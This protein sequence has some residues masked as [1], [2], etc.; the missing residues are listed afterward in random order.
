[1]L[2]FL[3]FVL[4]AHESRSDKLC[5]HPPGEFDRVIQKLGSPKHTEGLHRVL[6]GD[7]ATLVVA[8]SPAVRTS[9]AHFP[10]LCHTL[11]DCL[12]D[13]RRP[14][15]QPSYLGTTRKVALRPQPIQ[16]LDVLGECIADEGLPS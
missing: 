8:L 14:D 1:M 16:G 12:S 3:D 4:R 2:G 6:Y 10:V 15:M 11:W 5:E 7:S 13:Q 9:S